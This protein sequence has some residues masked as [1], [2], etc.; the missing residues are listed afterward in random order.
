MISEEKI[1]NFQLLF[2]LIHSQIGIGIIT[3][4]NEVFMKAKVDGWISVL[5]AG[6]I[7]QIIILIFG[8]LMARFPSQQLYNIMQSLLGKWLGKLFILFYTI[9]FICLAG[10]FFAKFAVII[11]SWMMP[12]TPKWILI[13]LIMALAIYA[14]IERLQIIARFFI[15]SFIVIVIFIIASTYT[16]KDANLIYVLP[17]AGS[18]LTPILKGIPTTLYSFQGFEYLLLI[19]PIVNSNRKGIIKTATIANLFVTLFYTY[20][21]LLSLLF[22]SPNELK[23]IPEPN[24]YLFKSLNFEIIERPD[25]IFTSIWI[26]IVVTTL[27]MI[28]YVSSLGLTVFINA[29]HR[30]ISVFIVAGISFF[31][32]MTIIGEYQI[33]SVAKIF[34]PFIFLFAI[35]LPILFTIIAITFKKKEQKDNN[36]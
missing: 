29:N 16:L 5:L 34:N 23:L 13:L 12:L 22:F 36:E 20:T 7:I 32:A 17:I 25:L 31:L 28:F 9:Y 30:K 35:G 14:A 33:S 27:I 11:K 21:V 26:V 3:M 10:I 6:I 1:T 4:P 15:I 19:F 2:I 18:G 24:L 8:F